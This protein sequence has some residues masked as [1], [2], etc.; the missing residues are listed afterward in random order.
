MS[1]IAEKSPRRGRPVKAY[2]AH[3][4]M[5][6]PP[7]V[8]ELFSIRNRLTKSCA[9]PIQEARYLNHHRLRLVA[10]KM[11]HMNLKLLIA[12]FVITS[13]QIFAQTGSASPNEDYLNWS[14]AQAERIGKSTIKEFRSGS[15]FDFR[16]MGQDKA[17]MYQVQIT[18]FTPEV[19]RASARVHQIKNRLSAD[20]TRKLVAEAEAEGDLVAMVEIDPG[21]GS[22]VVPLDWRIFL[23]PPGFVPG[24]DGAVA[25]GKAPYLRTVKAFS[26]VKR[27]DYEYDVFWVI[28]PLTNEKKESVLTDSMGSFEIM[29]GIYSKEG[30]TSWAIPPSLRERA[31]RLEIERKSK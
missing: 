19:I 25:G 12:F 30:K 29:V 22:G 2:K 8:C 5:W 15:S 23:Q 1:S 4:A 11:T 24:S 6:I 21:E 9:S 16:I 18:V 10:E 7:N 14:L 3:D 31:K 28:F 13:I 26:G 27:R 20:E 17:F